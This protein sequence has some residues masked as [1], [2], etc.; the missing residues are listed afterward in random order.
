[1]VEENRILE[2]KVKEAS[3][4][5]RLA[6]GKAHRLAEEEGFSLKEIGETANKL[7]IKIVACE[8]GCF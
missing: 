1:M 2:E 3:V 7:K 8:L 5:G 6:C 4:N